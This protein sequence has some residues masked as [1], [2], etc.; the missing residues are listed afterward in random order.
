VTLTPHPLLVPRF[1]K[2]SR[3]VPLLYLRAFVTCE[4]GGTIYTA[5]RNQTFWNGN[6]TK[7]SETIFF[8]E[9]PIRFKIVVGN[10]W[11]Q[12]VKNFKYLGLKC[13][14]NMKIYSQKLSKFAQILGILNN[15]FKP[16]L[17]QISRIKVYNALTLQILSYLSEI[18]IF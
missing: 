2:Q 5:K 16:N 1:K 9:D 6:T 12:D 14:M 4:K 15:T 3:A 11:L 7:K 10:R 17:V 8:P 18:L 13:P